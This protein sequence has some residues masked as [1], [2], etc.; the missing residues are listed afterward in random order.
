MAREVRLR[1]PGMEESAAQEAYRILRTNIQ[2]CAADTRTIA[3]T[4]AGTDEGKTTISICLAASLA[5]LGK[6]V[7]LPA[8]R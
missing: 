1:L 2:L 8:G 6:R 7:L 3:I 4:S 5:E